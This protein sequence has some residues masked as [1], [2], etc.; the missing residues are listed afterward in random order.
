M[1]MLDG[2]PV[3]LGQGTIKGVPFM[4][5]DQCNLISTLPEII[6]I[7]AAA[8]ATKVITKLEYIIVLS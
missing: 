1:A 3:A 6:M 7:I 4:T 5:M 8:Y 2:N